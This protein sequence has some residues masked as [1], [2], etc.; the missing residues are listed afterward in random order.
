[1]WLN[2]NTVPHPQDDDNCADATPGRWREYVL[3]ENPC[4]TMESGPLCSLKWA[5]AP[6]LPWTA[7]GV[8]LH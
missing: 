8:T 6:D 3:R 7:H 1:M 5:D 2:K 4:G